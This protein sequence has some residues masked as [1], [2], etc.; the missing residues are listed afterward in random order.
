MK[1]VRTKTKKKGGG[2]GEEKAKKA[3]TAVYKWLPTLLNMCFFFG[4][5]SSPKN[6]GDAVWATLD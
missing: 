2:E 3:L 4:Y 1:S 6:R 5:Q